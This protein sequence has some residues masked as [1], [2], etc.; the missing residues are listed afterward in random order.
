MKNVAIAMTIA[1]LSSSAVYAQEAPQLTRVQVIAEY[2]AAIAA[3][4]LPNSGELYSGSSPEAV[5]TKTRD[6]VRAEVRL[7]QQRGEIV[8]GEQYPRF[9]TNAAAPAVSR[10]QVRAELA[11]YLKANPHPVGEVTL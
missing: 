6:E 2:K 11:A 8:S 1:L 7:A 10:A 9:E 5:S 4:Q 3:G